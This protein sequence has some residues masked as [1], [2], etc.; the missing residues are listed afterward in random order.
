M[1]ST[2]AVHETIRASIHDDAANRRTRAVS[3]ILAARAKQARRDARN[4]RATIAAFVVLAI[5][6]GL[7][8]GSPI[9]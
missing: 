1:R 4:A 2:Y 6:G 3:A 9:L 5:V 8:L 7:L